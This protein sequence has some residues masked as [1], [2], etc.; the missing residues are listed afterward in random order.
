MDQRRR[1]DPERFVAQCAAETNAV[2][3]RCLQVQHEPDL[4]AGVALKSSIDVT[5]VGPRLDIGD[6]VVERADALER[7]GVLI[8]PLRTLAGAAGELLELLGENTAAALDVTACR[9]SGFSVSRL[10]GW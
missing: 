4:T 5:D 8:E 3:W 7:L 6:R 1:A 9:R 2:Y 10:S